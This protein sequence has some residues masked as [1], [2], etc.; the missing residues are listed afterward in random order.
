MEF[1]KNKSTKY[2]QR[3]AQKAILLLLTFIFVGLSPVFALKNT[4]KPFKVL[5]F[6]NGTWDVAHISFVNEA[7]VWFPKVAKENGFVYESTNDWNQLNVDKLADVSVV[8]FLDDVPPTADQR[9]VFEEY[10]HN[11]GAFISFHVAAYNDNPQ[12]WDWYYNHF[13]GVGRYAG[14]TWK[15]TS[16]NLK[17]EVKEHPISAGM[18]EI[19]TSQPN[20]WYRWE[21]NLRE[22]PDIQVLVS[23]DPS[24]FPLGT[25]P[26]AHE[27]WYEG[28]YPVVWTNN[29]YNMLYVNMG[30]NDMLYNPDR[31]VS[32]TFQN[33]EQN[34]LL[35][36]G[37]HWLATKK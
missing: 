23:I 22:N 21:K 8:L 33:V 18:S 31:T 30:H 5:A 2:S 32:Y 35:L 4:E 17:V 14:N 34:K 26:K 20:E 3:I 13:I 37:L 1:I 12:R 11:G 24:S 16:A 10:M 19:F 28:D 25:G 29:K 6:Y 27:I 7:N 36:N 9:K 15:P